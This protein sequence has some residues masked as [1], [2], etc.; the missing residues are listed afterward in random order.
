MDARNFGRIVVLGASG[1]VG[2][3]VAELFAKRAVDLRLVS[4]GPVPLPA[5]STA[6]VHA[7]TGDLTDPA[8]MLRAVSGADLILHLVCHRTSTGRWQVE[9]GDV[10][11]EEINI[12]TVRVL[13]AALRHGSAPG[14][15]RSAP[16]V[17]FAG[18]TSQAGPT[19]RRPIDGT[20]A[21][22]PETL[23][24]KQKL[25]AER[26]LVSATA[27]GLVRGVSVR[28]TTVYGPSAFARDHG[29]VSTLTREALAGA[30]L[31]LWTDGSVKR[32]LMYVDDA[33]RAFEAA[34]DHVDSLYGRYFPV[35]SG[36]PVRIDGLFDRVAHQVAQETGRPP[37]PII[38][39]DPS[40]HA[41]S[42]ERTSAVIDPSAFAS[43]T[44][45]SPRVGLEEGLTR[46]V[47]GL[48]REPLTAR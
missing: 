2:S 28:L 1:F 36:S 7:L 29:V 40:A 30:P 42:G 46:T 15:A 4:R 48:F 17:I 41:S 8:F 21:D 38:R 26:L 34:A 22:R 14:S 9:A 19:L 27:A 11:A 18:S 39:R 23:Y 13:L 24:D 5:E 3:A 44:G 45:W 20:G 6:R 25:T 33:A 32:D 47:H 43:A 10:R 37:V 16:A 31:T 12:G 35:G